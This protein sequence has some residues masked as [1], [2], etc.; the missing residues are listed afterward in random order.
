VRAVDTN[1]LA[2]YYLA[3]DPAQSRIAK[4]VLEAS[5]VFVPKTVVLELAWVLQSVA[6]QP[7]RK[8]QDCLRHLVALPGVTVEDE[9]EVQAALE[10]CA[11]GLEFADALH[12][13]ASSACTEM[14]TFDDRF[15]RR[16]SRAK[17]KTPENRPA[18]IP[19]APP[20]AHEKRG[21]YRSHR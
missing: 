7:A 19:P 1:V 6:G 2:R 8:V 21:R 13:C 15:V 12:L 11:R 9:E 10:L 18:S 14:L 3:D 5:D 16:A 4:R 20:A 17:P